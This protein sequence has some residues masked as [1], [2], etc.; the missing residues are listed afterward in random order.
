MNS[1]IVLVD[2]D[3]LGKLIDGLQLGETKRKEYLKARWL[4]YVAWWDSRA[5][6][7]KWRYL[8]LRSA[9][10]IGGALIPAV[11]GLREMQDLKTYDSWFAAASI[12]VSLVIA[13]CAGL[14]SLFGFG[15]IWREKRTAAE[16]IKSEGFSFLQLSGAYEKH[17]THDDAYQSFASNV[18]DL[19][20]REIKDYI[21]AITPRKPDGDGQNRGAGGKT[22]VNP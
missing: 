10:I 4:K 9:V 18:E 11:V 5:R 19:I 12:A 13:I 21:V 1:R 6:Y 7:A 22:D 20:T 8:A 3:E 14:E 2:L 16:V 17:K 15:D